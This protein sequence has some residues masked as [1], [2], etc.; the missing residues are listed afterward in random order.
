MNMESKD[1]HIMLHQFWMAELAE[2]DSISL[3]E[4]SRMK[5]FVTMQHDSYVP[6][7]SNVSISIPRRTI[8]VGTT[9]DTGAYLKGQTGNTRYLPLWIGK[10]VDR[11]RLERDRDQILAEAIAH[12]SA[13]LEDWWAMDAEL[14]ERAQEE[15]EKRRERPVYEDP[16]NDWLEVDRFTGAIYDDGA[17]VRFI[18]DET[19]WPEIAKWYL[20]LDTPEKWKDRSL[21]MQIAATL[22]SLGWIHESI[23]RHGHKAR[24]WKK[25]ETRL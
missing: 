14:E 10:R 7:Y 23:F 21:Q 1:A 2:L 6:K 24:I 8:F 4:D 11:D 5:A 22:K 15:R 18:Q 3:T 20:K 13:R 25:T 17:P 9:N 12:Y 19:S 16:L